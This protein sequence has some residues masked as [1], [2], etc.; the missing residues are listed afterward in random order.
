MAELETESFSVMNYLKIFFRRKELIIIPAFLGIIGGVCAGMVLPKLYKS[1]TIILVEEGKT[2]NPLFSQLAVSTTVKQRL[3]TIKE[4]MLGWHS[5][6]KLVKRLKL[7]KDIKTQKQYENLI[8]DIRSD[9]AIK[10][11][12]N[13][14]IKLSYVGE[15]PLGTQAIVKNVTDIFIEQNRQIQDKETADAI[16]FIEEQLHVYK[17]KIK[18]AEIARMQDRLDELLIDSTENHPV[19][20]QLRE[21]ITLKKDELK[22]ENLEY[23][24]A[25]QLKVETTDPLIEGIQQALQNIES[26]G[27]TVTALESPEKNLFKI[28]L[29]DKLQ[30]VLARDQKVN[31]AIYNVLLQRLETAKITQRLQAS[32]EGTRYTILE[33][34]RIPLEPFQP[35]K[36]LLVFTGLFIGIVTGFGL[37]VA[38]EFLDKSFIDVEETKQHFG[39]PLLGAISRINTEESIR[40]EKDKMRWV[41]TLTLVAGAAIVLVTH[42]IINLLK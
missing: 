35:N 30:N 14:I 29:L 12:G 16:T 38:A 3:N 24:E 9:I 5:L 17:G 15:N 28:E 31:E 4:S 41:Y 19:V 2:D 21:Q 39:E 8:D 18:S 26:D 34:P 1:S 36:L 6:V 22:K 7:D 32:K 25:D 11:Q 37:V 23:T 20:K 13:N 33:P 40:V 42:A 10:L 27:K